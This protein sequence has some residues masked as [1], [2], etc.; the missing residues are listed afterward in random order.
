[1]FFGVSLTLTAAIIMAFLLWMTASEIK[2]PILAFIAVILTFCLIIAF[3]M[4]A[5]SDYKCVED[6]I[7][8]NINAAKKINPFYIFVYWPFKKITR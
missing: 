6:L 3:I 2:E 1:M 5:I 8:K 7:E 4:P